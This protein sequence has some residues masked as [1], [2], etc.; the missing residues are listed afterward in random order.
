MAD[1]LIRLFWGTLKETL[2]TRPIRLHQGLRFIQ[3]QM[4]FVSIETMKSVLSEF[5]DFYNHSRPHQSITQWANACDGVERASG[6]AA[7]ESSE[8]SGSNEDGKTQN[9][10]P[11]CT[12]AASAQLI[13][14]Q[15]FDASS[16]TTNLIA[17]RACSVPAR[18]AFGCWKCF[19]HICATSAAALCA[20]GMT[21]SI[22]RSPNGHGKSLR[23]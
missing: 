9:H 14:A 7:G 8:A 3:E 19:M 5:R 4:R 15:Q 10:W 18:R 20:W 22:G 11:R 21:R 2:D 23:G 17:G 13:C 1:N 16:I 12:S 6:E